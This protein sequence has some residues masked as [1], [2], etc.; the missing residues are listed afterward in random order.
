MEVA[1]QD[2]REKIKASDQPGRLPVMEIFTSIQ[3]EGFHQGKPADFIRLGGCDVGCVWCDTMDSWDVG[4][5]PIMPVNDIVKE[6]NAEPTKF[7]VV[8]GGEPLMHDLTDL[9]KEL[10]Q[11]DLNT[12]IETSG[13]YPLSG[14]WDWICISPK[15]FKAPKDE[16]LKAAHELKIVVYNESD[17][18]WA[19]K[20]AKLVN[21]D[22]RLYLQPEWSTQETMLPVIREYISQHPEWEISVQL[23]KYLKVR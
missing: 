5:H 10:K 1:S 18:E 6:L 9:C 23:H 12:H 19:E 22:C 16:V 17:L 3:G 13:A 8:T 2:K 21:A 15:K 20:H 11:N 14:E 7:V 4:A